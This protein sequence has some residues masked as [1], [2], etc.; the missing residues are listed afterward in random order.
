MIK[1]TDLTFAFPKKDLYDHVS[2]D[3]EKGQH[4]AF[5]GASGSG[6]STLIQMIMDT[7]KYH[8]AGHIDIEAGC[9]IGYMS[10]FISSDDAFSMTV[11]DFIAEDFIR[12]QEK[13]EDLCAQMAHSEDLDLLLEDYQDALDA[14]QAI[15]GDAFES[16]IH[17]KLGLASLM[18][19]RDLKISEISGGEFKLIQIIK[20]MLTQPDVLIMDEPDVFLDFENL[21]AL[22]NLIN[23]HKGI[24]LVITHNRYLLNHCFN[25]IIHLENKALQSYHGTYMDYNFTLLESKIE[26]QELAI[27]D[28]EEIERN[29]ALIH[30]LRLNATYSS[31][32]AKGRSLRARVKYQERLEARQIQ[33]PFVEI[34]QPNIVLACQEDLEDVVALKI[35]H[36]DVDF[37]ENL[38]K[39][40]NLEIKSTDK[41]ALIGSNG[42]GKTTL[43]RTIMA[44]RAEVTIHDQVKL[45][46]LS[47]MQGETLNNDATIYEAFFDAGFESY[48]KIASF[49]FNYGFEEDTLNHNIGTLSGGEK[50]ILQL[51]CVCG[52]D[53]NM[54]LL[55]EPTSHLD[56]YAQLALEEAI[57]NYKGGILM[58]SHDYYTIANSVDYVLMIEDKTV[59]KISNRKFRKMIYINHYN[60]DYLVLEQE[61][62]TLET[63]IAMALR[64]TKF[65]KAKLLCQPLEEIIKKMK[66]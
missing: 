64:A 66:L 9:R 44:K 41:V 18:K 49:L 63:Q 8:Y 7:D 17:K 19:H 21:E 43:L 2:F 4:A 25:K 14:F 34:K 12:Y 38:L 37:E 13:I 58:I 60:K 3:L 53:A 6:K 59:K 28:Q 23:S 29:E 40:V 61:K 52:Q 31:E 30:Q 62:K 46:Y 26:L 65:E 10:Q 55:D 56:T 35:D 42:T 47:Q 5:I 54:L 57:K 15:G 1:I 20:E 11:F 33:A 39:D 48:S 51:A 50:N 22:K 27:A 36:L 24:L 16:I 45:A 32:A